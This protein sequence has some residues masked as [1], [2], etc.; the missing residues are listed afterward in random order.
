MGVL[1]G[2]GSIHRV[3]QSSATSATKATAGTYDNRV[4]YYRKK[5]MKG[6]GYDYLRLGAD[7]DNQVPKDAVV[8]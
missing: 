1:T 3:F 4:L 8:V 2:P 6:A 7:G 5:L